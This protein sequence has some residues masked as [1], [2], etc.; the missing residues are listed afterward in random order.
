[1]KIIAS[2]RTRNEA[3]HIEQWCE[4]YSEFA[5][6]LIIADGGSTDNTIELALKYPKVRVRNYP[7]EVT[8][9]DGTKR[10]PDGPHIQFLVDW[11]TKIRGN[12]IIHQDTDQRP[13]KFLKQDI[14][15]ILEETDKDFLQVTQIYLWGKDQYF[16]KLS[17][18]GDAWS[19]GLWAWRLSARIKIIDRMPHYVFSFDGKNQI[20]IND[21][22]QR[23]LDIQP[24][25]CFMH[26]G[27]DS[28]ENALAHV[29]YYRKTGLIEH[30]Q[31][32]TVF[33]GELKP[34]ESWMVE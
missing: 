25:Y 7:V 11:A 4:S 32:P 23:K 29:E 2:C 21:M 16:P 24:P 1:M 22:P 27:W 31:Y 12:W 10:N 18:W 26:F 9:K 8:L 13:N 6:V 30:M 5:D 28:Q 15:K 3:K 17:K 14:R 19:Q 33:G 20:D 34:L